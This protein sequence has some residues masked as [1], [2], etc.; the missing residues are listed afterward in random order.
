MLSFCSKYFPTEAYSRLLI[1]YFLIKQQLK[2]KKE[3]STWTRVLKPIGFDSLFFWKSML[4]DEYKWT[5]QGENPQLPNFQKIL[6][7]KNSQWV[8]WLTLKNCNCQ[9]TSISYVCCVWLD[10]QYKYA[11][12]CMDT[13]RSQRQGL[14]KSE[15][16][17]FDW[18]GWAVS[19]VICLFPL[20]NA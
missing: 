18:N 2:F 5:T 16:R 10:A 12:V 7:F 8:L 13:H 19:S 9:V 6:D 11:P 15:A 3:M 14:T 17:L 20:S 4:L 1:F